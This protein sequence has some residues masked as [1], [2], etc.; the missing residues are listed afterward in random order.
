[1]VNRPEN[2]YSLLQEKKIGQAI[3][4]KVITD[5]NHFGWVGDT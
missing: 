1:M 3:K 2:L 5:S 4:N